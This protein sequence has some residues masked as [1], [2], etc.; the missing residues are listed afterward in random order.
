M[1]SNSASTVAI[2]APYPTF[3]VEKKWKYEKYAGT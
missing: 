1:V 3:S 2:D